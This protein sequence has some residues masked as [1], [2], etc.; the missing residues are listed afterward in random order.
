MCVMMGNHLD[1]DID[2]GIREMG[3]RMI[4][5]LR[6]MRS[7]RTLTHLLRGNNYK[8]E[9][10][11]EA[12][13]LN[14]MFP[15]LLL[16]MVVIIF[17]PLKTTATSIEDP[18]KAQMK[19]DQ[20]YLAAQSIET[21]SEA[22]KGLKAFIEDKKL[23]YE[24]RRYAINKLGD[25]NL[26]EL[27]DYF[28]ELGTKKGR[29]DDKWLPSDTAYLA[30][31]KIRTHHETDPEKQ[32]EILIEGL[33]APAF[34]VHDWVSDELCSRGIQRAY[35]A[36]VKSMKKR[37]GNTPDEEI[38]INTCRKQLDLLAEYPTRFE[39]LA[40]GLKEGEP[41]GS[42]N[43]LKL[44]AVKELAVMKTKEANRELAD[45]ALY[46]QKAGTTL[47]ESGIRELQVYYT[48][49][50]TIFYYLKQNGWS[51]QQLQSYGVKDFDVAV[52]SK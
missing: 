7:K 29:S 32:V 24:D 15:V 1:I 3:M 38:E 41:S 6:C 10:L 23:N 21:R 44:W 31:W 36:I 28:L 30:Y 11:V 43:K 51:S 46:L 40:V 25:L 27:E 16:T 20:L 42:S 34:S 26:E 39:A 12:V 47:F 19:I 8:A 17:N 48:I 37:F 50:S 18:T 13:L 49:H 2:E 35:P 14:I 22:I 4:L 52:R 33:Q 9:R 5:A 45:Y